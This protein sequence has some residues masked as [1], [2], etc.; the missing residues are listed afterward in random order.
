[1]VPGTFS[2]GRSERADLRTVTL[3]LPDS[4]PR[5][6]G[7][8]VGRG[9]A[10]AIAR[11]IIRRIRTGR[12]GPGGRIVV[13]ADAR[14][15][16]AARPVLAALRDGVPLLLT[17]SSPEKKKTREGK[18]ALEDRL[19]RA[20]V[21]RDALV[22]ACG[23]GALLDLAGF[24][25]ATYMRGVPWIALPTTLLAMVDASVGGK[26]A[27]NHPA[28]K[29]LLGAF[30]QPEAIWADVEWLGSLPAR[31]F[32]SGLAEVVKMAAALSVPF[33]RDL[34][35]RADDILARRPA[36]LV[37]IVA[38]SVA[39]KVRVVGGDEREAGPRQV[40]NFGHTIAHGIEA[41]EPG[42]WRHGEAVAVG[43]AVEARI[44]ERVCGF[45]PDDVRRLVALL[46]RLGLPVSPA[47]H[48]DP[49]R[50]L[51]LT[52][53]DKKARAA[54]TRYALPVRL[55]R[56]A[57]MP[58]GAWTHAVPAGVARACWRRAARLDGRR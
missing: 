6:V 1:M 57:R 15:G 38:R 3:R 14:A 54:E 7:V 49:A 35:A 40:L 46:A 9:L 55:G 10:R 34:E 51:R 37:D 25:A 18:A 36:R 58:S 16:R 29:N 53:S 43:L 2:G 19:L 31:E 33:F 56:M 47:K 27:V 13:I 42:R 44:A 41:A 45:P 5:R 20:G 8:H 4:G 28:G 22:V 23:G 26:V 48:L 11:D 21:G 17:I 32:R 12:I 50:V 24:A 52:R 39:L 30:H